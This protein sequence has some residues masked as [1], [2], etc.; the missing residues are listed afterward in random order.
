MQDQLLDRLAWVGHRHVN[1]PVRGIVLR[2]HGLGAMGMKGSADPLDLEWAHHGA[3][4]IE[5]FHLPWAWMNDQT[6][7]LYDEVVDAVRVRY[8]LSADLPLITTGGSMGGHGSLTYAFRSRHRVTATQ[9]NCPVCD[10]PFHYTERPDLPRTMHQAFGSLGDITAAMEERSPLH[11]AARMPD[12]AYQII[13]GARDKAVNKERHSDRLVAA[14]RQHGRRVDYLE[15]PDMEHC[16]PFTWPA[17]RQMVDFVIG[18][19]RG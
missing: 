8:G 19:L 18:Q 17:Y 16:Q 11:Q 3:L 2:F 10:L 9:A 6:R 4:V 12:I 1:G 15:L 14:L 13:H 5:P 7:D